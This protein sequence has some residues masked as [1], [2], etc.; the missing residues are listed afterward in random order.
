MPDRAHRNPVLWSLATALLWIAVVPFVNAED[1]QRT[2]TAKQ[3]VRQSA[4]ARV[5][6]DFSKLPVPR[7]GIRQENLQPVYSGLWTFVWVH[8]PQIRGCVLDLLCYEHSGMTYLSHRDLG[9]GAIEL[10][11]RSTKNPQMLLITT[12][13][14][15]PGAVE[16]VAR[17]E[18]DK[19]R[20]PNGKLPDEL[21]SPNLCFRVKR[22]EE[23]FSHFPDAFPEF[24]SRCFIFTEKGRTFLDKTVRRKLP[25][26]AA[27]DLR[28]KP[29]WVQVYWPVWSP[30][31][32]PAT[33]N[34]WYNNSPNR[35]TVPVMG[36]VS[37][38]RKHLVAIANDTSD[39]MTQAWQQCLHNNP[40]WAPKNA[41]P[42]QR[43]WRVK[44]YVMPN[45]PDA[46]LTRVA[47]D[48]PNVSKLKRK[49]VSGK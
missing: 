47:Q 49:R 32:Q 5:A 21:P 10:K 44:I 41:P 14:P 48:F 25:P 26:A 35:Y 4:P 30:P 3:S 37:R 7:L 31:P 12:V 9:K 42:V 40:H 36:V 1:A 17:A 15:E 43:R 27:D 20:A 19:V 11:H 28:N 46:L 22:A 45:D 2:T 23:G 8:V 34:T 24:I 16:F 39:R 18:V 6:N 33:G 29:P 13:T 38:D